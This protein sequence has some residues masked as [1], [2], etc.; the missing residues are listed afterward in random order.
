[1]TGET[2]MMVEN[3]ANVVSDAAADVA[4]D[5]IGTGDFAVVE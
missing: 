1:M 3:E 5:E 4:A 2:W